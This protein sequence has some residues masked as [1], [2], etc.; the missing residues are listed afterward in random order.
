M[1]IWCL[2]LIGI[3]VPPL[4][5][6]RTKDGNG[7]SKRSI[8]LVIANDNS[9]SIGDGRILRLASVDDMAN[10]IRSKENSENTAHSVAPFF[11][12]IPGVNFNLSFPV[13][14]SN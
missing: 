9:L 2:R 5:V 8:K 12:F 1:S 13:K 4:M 3:Y 11:V 7:S 6:P 10:V 14:V